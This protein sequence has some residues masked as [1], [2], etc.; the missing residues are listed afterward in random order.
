MA[1]E[2]IKS[3]DKFPKTQEFLKGGFHVEKVKDTL[4]LSDKEQ[5]FG[6]QPCHFSHV[7]NCFYHLLLLEISVNS[8]QFIN[9]VM[10]TYYMEGI[11]LIHWKTKMITI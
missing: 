4:F 7:Y 10:L 6:I 3:K 8:I 11:G 2:Q 9:N 5:V 1:Q